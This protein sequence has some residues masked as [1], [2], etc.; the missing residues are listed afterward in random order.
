MQDVFDKAREQATDPLGLM[1]AARK[2]AKPLKFKTPRSVADRMVRPIK[3][4]HS[5]VRKF[6]DNPMKHFT[7][8]LTDTR[9]RNRPSGT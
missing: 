4:L 3:S 9:T 8:R 1:K 7:K 5:K 2:V 6:L